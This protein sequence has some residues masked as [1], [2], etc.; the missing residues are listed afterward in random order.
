[1]AVKLKRLKDQTIVITGATSGIGLVTA[2]MAAERG[3]R[4]VLAARS[5]QALHELAEEIKR[6]GGRAVAV[7]ADVSKEADVRRIAKTAQ[8]AF[9]GFDTW[10]N[11]AG[12]GMF[13]R[14][15][16]TPVE[17]MRKLFEVN[18][19]SVVYGSLEAVAHLRRRGGA[20][21]NVGSAVGERAMML[22]GVYSTT[23]HA[24]H[25]FT[26][27]L[28]M[29][30]EADGAPV[31]VTLIKPAAIDTPFAR[32]AKNFME[33]EPALPPPLYAPETVARAI[34]HSAEKPTRDLFVGGGAKAAA[35]LGY[36]APRL[37]DRL[38]TSR[39]VREAQKKDGPRRLRVQNAVDRP[40]GRLAERGGNPGHVAESSLYTQS[41]MRPTLSRTLLVGAGLALLAWL[42]RQPQAVGEA[43]RA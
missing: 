20:L 41:K 15:E 4:L 32:H 33:R 9:G 14:V 3:A 36:Y 8:K 6:G 19:W 31:S 34:L 10:V 1:M 40:S 43:H 24:V 5:E 22:Q 35:A 11:N 18:F 29:D 17:D 7:V 23:K 21:I 38:M 2:R 25:G 27:A 30:L 37:T 12:V 16:A 39:L 42:R 13:G 26:D 28:R